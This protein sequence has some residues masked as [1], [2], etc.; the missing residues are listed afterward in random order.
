MKKITVNWKSY[1]GLILPVAVTLLL[2]QASKAWVRATL[3]IGQVLRPERGWSQWVRLTHL[4]NTGAAGGV[5]GG[6]G[7]LPPLLFS[8]AICLGVLYF[9][10]RLRQDERLLRLGLGLLLG[11]GLGNIL[12]RLYQ[13]GA[14]TDFISIG[15]LPVFNLADLF[16]LLGALTLA[17]GL[18]RR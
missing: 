13:A 9:Y 10:P 16:V 8:L 2:D 4:R 6:L 18:W 17:A 7:G 5:L 1:S 12:D 3:A 15:S 11:G 14:V